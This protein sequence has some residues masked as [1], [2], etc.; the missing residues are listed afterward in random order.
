MHLP[1]KLRLLFLL[2]FCV[3]K[4]AVDPVISIIKYMFKTVQHMMPLE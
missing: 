1:T 3:K 4:N 2:V